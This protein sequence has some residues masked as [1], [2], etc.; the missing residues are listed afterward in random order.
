MSISRLQ[1]DELDNAVG[2]AA[3][4]SQPLNQHCI[5]M[6]ESMLAGNLPIA[7]FTIMSAT[8]NCAKELSKAQANVAHIISI[9]RY[10]QFSSYADPIAVKE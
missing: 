10:P 5:A 7:D 6:L 9:L 4:I 8:I 3:R 2:N 1:A